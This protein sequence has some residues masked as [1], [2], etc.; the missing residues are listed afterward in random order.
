M[1]QSP[2]DQQL[3]VSQSVTARMLCVRLGCIAWVVIRHALA[4]GARSTLHALGRR[5]PDRAATAAFIGALGPAFVKIAQLLSMRRDQLPPSWCDR[6]AALV[7]RVPCPPAQDIAAVLASAYGR[8]LPF[9]WFDMTPVA[10]GSIATVHR[11]GLADGRVLAVKIRRRGA[12]RTLAADLAIFAMAG[13]AAGWLPGLRRIPLREMTSQISRAVARQADLTADRRSLRAL[14]VSLSAVEYVRVPATIDSLC[15]AEVV[16]MEFITGLRPL[17]PGDIPAGSRR[18]IVIR[19]LTMMYEML[20]ANGLVHCDLHYGNV[21]VDQD[22]RVVLLDGG[23]VVPLPDRVREQFAGFFMG[24]ATG[25]GTRCAQIVLA[26]AARVAPG[27]DAEGFVLGLSR[28]IA[29]STGA[30][31]A[32][33]SLAEF[34]GRLFSLQRR[35]RIFAAP[36]FV[37]PLLALLVLEGIIRGLDE[38]V[39]FQAV[40]IPVLVRV[41]GLPAPTTSDSG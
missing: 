12:T 15:R 35:H 36:E 32:E 11:A 22:D 17:R 24:M 20:F 9:A 39:D 19:T 18:A 3:A 33:F 37:F 13:R 30:R 26:S 5:G 40:A 21:Y 1:K 25:R 29:E 27:C 38:T 10:S 14:R 34:A 41:L 8:E 16:A 4:A 6:L 23:F 28:L 31:A 7:D 2:D